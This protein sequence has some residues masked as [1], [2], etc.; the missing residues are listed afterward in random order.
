[1]RDL[2]NEMGLYIKTTEFDKQLRS[3]NLK[4]FG[5]LQILPAAYTFRLVDYGKPSF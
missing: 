5:Q 1:M 3:I 2:L 4:S